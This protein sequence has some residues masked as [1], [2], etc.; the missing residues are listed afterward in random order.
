MN[1][2]LKSIQIKENGIKNPDNDFC[3]MNNQRILI[4]IE[5]IV[6]PDMLYKALQNKLFNLYTVLEAP[7]QVIYYNWSKFKEFI[8]LE[9][10]VKDLRF[11]YLGFVQRYLNFVESIN[12]MEV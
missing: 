6:D 3:Y 7:E 11:D 2:E 5:S 1:A 9:V 8:K 4:K 12:L 10:E